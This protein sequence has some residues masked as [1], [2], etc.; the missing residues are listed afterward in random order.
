MTLPATWL[1]AAKARF[2]AQK[3]LNRPFTG[4]FTANRLAD[5]KIF[6]DL[7]QSFGSKAY[8]DAVRLLVNVQ[9]YGFELPASPAGDEFYQAMQDAVNRVLSGKQTPAAALKQAQKEAQT[10]ID[11]AKK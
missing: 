7:Y 3:R 11:K 1:K 9:K 8:D 6:E 5:V 4:T 2:D 10:A